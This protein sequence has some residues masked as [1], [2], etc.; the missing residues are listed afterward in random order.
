MGKVRRI[1]KDVIGQPSLLTPTQQQIVDSRA[2]PLNLNQT[3][4]GIDAQDYSRTNLDLVISGGER[5]LQEGRA[6]DQGW[7]EL[8]GKGVGNVFGTLAFETLKMP[9]YL[10]GLDNTYLDSIK[11]LQ[12][13]TQGQIFEVFTPPSVQEGDLLTQLKNPYFWASEGANGVGFMLSFLLPGQLIKAAGLGTASAKALT[14]LG[15]LQDTVVDGSRVI[16]GEGNTFGRLLMK[17]AGRTGRALDFG[18]L[19]RNLDSGAAVLTNAYFEASAEGAEIYDQ[20]IAQGRSKEE[21]ARAAADVFG[22]NLPLLLLSNTLVEKYIL[23]GF[24]RALKPSKGLDRITPGVIRGTEEV[25][26]VSGVRNLP[27]A[28]AGGVAQE[29]LLEE[30]LQTSI[31]QTEGRSFAEAFT[32]Y[33][34]NFEQMWTGKDQDATDFGK[35]VVLGGILGGGMSSVGGFAEARRDNE[36]LF[37]TASR[38]PTRIERFFGK[39]DR[40][41]TPGAIAVL[42]NAHNAVKQDSSA[43]FQKDEAGDII[44]LKSDAK[45]LLKDAVGM[46][47]L[48]NYYQDL[49]VKNDG[50]V[51]LT[52]K[53]FQQNLAQVAGKKG[54]LDLNKLVKGPQGISNEEALQLMQHRNDMEYFGNFL[55]FEGGKQLLDA[56]IDESIESI[57]ERYEQNT[58]VKMTEEQASKLRS[59]MKTRAKQAAEV[60]DT[61]EKDH[62]QN[63]LLV[64]Y[65]KNI[66][67][68]EHEQ[69]TAAYQEF[70]ARAK[71]ARLE[72]LADLKHV[73]S[74]LEEELEDK[75]K[76]SLTTAKE[77]LT[78]TYEE[79]S[80]TSG[81]TRL[82]ED[83]WN[84]TKEEQT[85]A[86]PTQPLTPAQQDRR[87]AFWDAVKQAGYNVTED[88]E[89]NNF[90]N[91]DLMIRHRN[92]NYELG[93]TG[94]ELVA[95][96]DDTE[97]RAKGLND[98][99]RKLPNY[100]I[101]P[102][103]EAERIR[104]EREAN[105]TG[106]D[107]KDDGDA[108]SDNL[109]FASAFE[110][111][112]LPVELLGTTGQQ[113][114]YDRDMNDV[115][116][117]TD[118]M[119]HPTPHPSPYQ[120]AFAKWIDGVEK[121]NF[122]VR[123]QV[124]HY[125]SRDGDMEI[126]FPEYNTSNRVA[127]E[128]VYAIVVDKND[129]PIL[130]EGLPLIAG[131]YKTD[132]KFPLNKPSRMAP[133][134]MFNEFFT[135]NGLPTITKQAFSDKSSGYVNHLSKSARAT[136]SQLLGKPNIA[137]MATS[138]L[139]E[140]LKPTVKQWVRQAY[141]DQLKAV[142]NAGRVITT[143]YGIT[144]GH[145][146]TFKTEDGGTW[147]FSP[148]DALDL[149]FDDKGKP[150]NFRIAK[151]NKFGFLKVTDTKEVG[152]YKAGILYVQ[153]PT[154]QVVPTHVKTL[155]KEQIDVIIYI[156]AQLHSKSGLAITTSNRDTKNTLRTKWGA[157]SL[158]I[159]GKDYNNNLP[160]FPGKHGRVSLMTM[161]LNWGKTG[162]ADYDIWVSNGVLHYGQNTMSLEALQN[163][164]NNPAASGELELLRTWLST[165]MHHVH[166]AMLEGNL[167]ALDIRIEEG[168]VVIDTLPNESYV[169]Q[170]LK[171]SYTYSPSKSR[172][173]QMG[174]TRYASRNLQLTPVKTPKSQKAPVVKPQTEPS[175]TTA[176]KSGYSQADTT[177]LLAAK[178]E[179]KQK[180]G[181]VK[182][183]IAMGDP[184][185]PLFDELKKFSG[186]TDAQI[187]DAAKQLEEMGFNTHKGMG[188][189]AQ[190]FLDTEAIRALAAGV[191]D[192]AQPVVEPKSEPQPQPT[193]KTEPTTPAFD[194]NIILQTAEFNKAFKA[195][196]EV[197]P[198]LKKIAA[199]AVEKIKDNILGGKPSD[200]RLSATDYVTLRS[201]PEEFSQLETMFAAMTRLRADMPN[202]DK[203][204]KADVVR[205]LVARAGVTPVRTDRFS[206]LAGDKKDFKKKADM[207]MSD[208]VEYFVQ[209]GI[210]RKKCD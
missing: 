62:S 190:D 158:R 55:S 29:G 59:D 126:H 53:E 16:S 155:Q 33:M 181:A 134:A 37:G 92:K 120:R 83:F 5:A 9:G 169:Q 177:K 73:E 208:K 47:V 193:A 146:I 28:L 44:G 201:T 94:D 128:D 123:L 160:V 58:G 69:A 96:S 57:K 165:K 31:S 11:W 206:K 119:V 80:S 91:D 135:A 188:K 205:Y 192:T 42:R 174:L 106:D 125:D 107:T 13:Q 114:L 189:G 113:I 87:K 3:N 88:E 136:L 38:T 143:A 194:P 63:R 25:A 95:V 41:E 204:I 32:K 7:L 115:L 184:H 152:G 129:N 22:K 151:A 79:L 97:V 182:T 117:T 159:A 90:L 156:L 210:L 30:G 39:Q 61:V 48:S 86:E 133:Y 21:A 100:K 198:E 199:R 112:A 196:Q 116:T 19:A 77:M 46:Q 141:D 130:F 60:F 75:D 1:Q 8:V 154:G 186:F 64:N 178:P 99:A 150:S 70:F 43:I 175:A 101:V 82:W 65:L 118:G 139:L 10:A 131:V 124:A 104:A 98:L 14:R 84:G 2:N 81:L 168:Q 166:Y 200:M 163:A 153:L 54:A 67:A 17:S 147:E 23:G 183:A 36:F 72:S 89:G 12:D 157:G 18:G 172:L 191:F 142:R 145:M 74:R 35:A 6:L 148:I 34:Q 85:T 164:Y 187:K 27:M 171:R 170:V 105:K 103:E 51:Q 209:R 195:G 132:T 93:S 197:S 66:P 52:D 102:K 40:K 76:S 179:L 138:A 167:P 180:A 20:M 71:A 176:K 111:R 49:L 56:H 161:L 149:E 68:E 121:I 108:P 4:L 24:G 140:E 173:N 185:K 202:R 144:N 45:E 26:K 109:N 15:K 203:L 137:G 207:R 78:K 110:E 122:K 50:N 127:G 162:H